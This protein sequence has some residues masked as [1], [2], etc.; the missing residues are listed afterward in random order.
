MAFSDRVGPFLSRDV[1]GY[2]VSGPQRARSAMSGLLCPQS[3]DGGARLVGVE[4]GRIVA[5]SWSSGRWR[6]FRK[7]VGATPGG[8]NPSLS[9]SEAQSDW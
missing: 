6:P 8:S 7:R 9:A 5:E 1:Q 2:G 4:R 3:A